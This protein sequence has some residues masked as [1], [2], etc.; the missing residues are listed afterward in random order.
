MGAFWRTVRDYPVMFDPNG[1]GALPVRDAV[2]FTMD[3]GEAV[4]LLVNDDDSDYGK[5]CRLKQN[6][7]NR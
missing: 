6:E 5:E 1:S 2:D 3:D 4:L 7:R